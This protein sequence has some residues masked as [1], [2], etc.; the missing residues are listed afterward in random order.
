MKRGSPTLPRSPPQININVLTH[1][2]LTVGAKHSAPAASWRGWA[3]WTLVSSTGVLGSWAL[4]S[5]V[6]FFSLVIALVAAVG[7]VSAGYLIPAL[8]ALRLLPLGRGER[9][10]CRALVPLAVALSGAGIFSAVRE[11]VH[12][13]AAVAP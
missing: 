10:L 12:D 6:P 4:A 7:D 2:V 1:L 11:I 3:A 9:W 8:L 5:G 13:S